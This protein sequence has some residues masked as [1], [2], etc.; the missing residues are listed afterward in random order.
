M[1]IFFQDF[2][3]KPLIVSFRGDYRFLSNFH[4]QP[5]VLDGWEYPSVENA[6]QAAK[7]TDPILRARC[8]NC[9]P[10]SAKTFGR[11]W[12]TRAALR[13][14][15]DQRKLDIMLLLLRQKF[16]PASYFGLKLLATGNAELIEG[17]NW[18]DVYW[19]RCR[20]EFHGGL[21]RNHLGR[22]LM[23]IRTELQQAIIQA[24]KEDHHA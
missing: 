16:A 12:R 9:A 7:T 10:A 8:L 22:L 5:V 17:N 14:D 23:Q 24:A 21:G 2:A 11:D 18:H 20:C 6:F 4:P 19:G 13:P 15:W 1:S 3:D